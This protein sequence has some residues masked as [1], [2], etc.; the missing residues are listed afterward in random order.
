[1]LLAKHAI[2]GKQLTGLIAQQFQN[3]I[4]ALTNQRNI[5]SN[6]VSTNASFYPSPSIPL[7]PVIPSK[8][9]NRNWAITY[10]EKQQYDTIFKAND[11][12]MVGYISGII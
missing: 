1:M 11:T 3:E 12:E 10:Q 7:P 8:D 2:E 4:I 5:Y 6:Q 9:P